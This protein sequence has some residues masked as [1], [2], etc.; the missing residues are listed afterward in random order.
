MPRNTRPFQI[1]QLLRGGALHRARDMAQRLGVSERTLYRDIEKLQAAGVPVEGTRG[2]GYRLHAQTTLPPLALSPQEFE[3]LN[4]GLAIAVE[5]AD[6]ELRAAAESVAAK[7]DAGLPETVVDTAAVWRHAQ[8]PFADAVR[9]FAQMPTVRAAIRAR[10]KLRIT[11]TAAD[12]T[13]TLRT[14]RPLHMDYLGRVWSVTAW[15]EL[16]AAHRVF[17]LDLIENAEAL[18]ELFADEPG[19]TLSDFDPARA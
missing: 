17:R 12:G 14:I 4:L 9:G 13:V 6:P 16:R 15:C 8:S 18:P 2:E 5:L 1:M 3:A 7:I 10:Q 11:Y 19:K